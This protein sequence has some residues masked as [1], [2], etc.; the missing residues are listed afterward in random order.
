MKK[1]L[2]YLFLSFSFVGIANGETIETQNYKLPELECMKK[3]FDKFIDVFGVYVVG[4]DKAPMDK[5]MHTAGVLA[6]Y[7]DNDEDG[8]PDDPKISSFLSKYNFIVPVWREKDREVFW[9][10]ALGTPCEDNIGMAA[11]MYYNYDEWAIGGIKKTGQWDTNLEEVWHVVS[12]G[13]YEVYPKY[14]GNDGS[15]LQ[16]AMNKARGGFF[17]NVPSTYPKNA[18]YSY[19]DESCDYHCQAHEYFYWILM[20][21]INALDLS[22]TDKCRPNDEWNICNKSQLK[23][24]DVLAYELLNN[25]DFVLPTRIPD[26]QYKSDVIKVY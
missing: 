3:T 11:S 6:Q 21:N 16:D 23:Q 19:Y 4:T 17:E 10:T 13:W 8:L 9:Q 5:V 25:Y 12:V 1:L 14:F 18:W 20:A 7:L 2:I 26:G 22:Y 15:M 24:K